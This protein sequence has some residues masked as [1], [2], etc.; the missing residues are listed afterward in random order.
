MRAIYLILLMRE[1][2]LGFAKIAIRT[3]VVAHLI[4]NKTGT[5]TNAADCDNNLQYV[6]VLAPLA[7]GALEAQDLQDSSP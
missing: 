1:Y 2:D 6:D 7:D 4:I 5:L 3:N